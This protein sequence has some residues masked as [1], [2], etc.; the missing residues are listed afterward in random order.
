MVA[1][2]ILDK[3]VTHCHEYPRP[4][5]GEKYYYNTEFISGKPKATLIAFGLFAILMSGNVLYEMY[6]IP[7]KKKQLKNK[8]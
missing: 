2:T 4:I 5:L 7:K 6:I 3:T 8:D 1:K